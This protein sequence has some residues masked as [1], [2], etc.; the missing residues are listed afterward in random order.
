MGFH[1]QLPPLRMCA[2]GLFISAFLKHMGIDN[3]QMHISVTKITLHRYRKLQEVPLLVITTRRVQNLNA[4][5][6]YKSYFAQYLAC[7]FQCASMLHNQKRRHESSSKEYHKC[8]FL[9]TQD[10][11]KTKAH[12]RLVKQAR[13]QWLVSQ[14]SYFTYDSGSSSM[15]NLLIRRLSS[16]KVKSLPEGHHKNQ[17]RPFH[18][19]TKDSCS[20]HAPE[21]INQTKSRGVKIRQDCMQIVAS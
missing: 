10:P 14:I 21:G 5:N 12:A 4:T 17:P 18:K 2:R 16:P 15:K 6:T 8:I 9:R 11:T 1:C 3:I 13:V 20:M 7:N 19:S